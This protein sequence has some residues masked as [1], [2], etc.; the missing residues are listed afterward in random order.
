MEIRYRGQLSWRDCL[1]A[2]AVH[3]RPH[4]L[5]WVLRGLVALLSLA[6]VVYPE[7]RGLNGARLWPIAFL[8]VALAASPWWLAYLTV[9]QVWMRSHAFGQPQSGIISPEGIRPVEAGAIIRWRDYVM[10]RER[11]GLIM[12]YATP[13]AFSALS[14]SFFSSLSDWEAFGSLVRAR[15]P[16]GTRNLRERIWSPVMV[17]LAL[18]LAAA[19]IA[20]LR[21]AA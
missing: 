9:R 17:I 13:G 10:Y 20:T 15:V 7:M 8:S 14:R 18:A 2:C 1:R 3:Y 4:P 5:G 6:L 19:L 21:G 16:R 12:L 11:P